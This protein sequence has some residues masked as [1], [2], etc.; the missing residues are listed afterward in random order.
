MKRLQCFADFF[1]KSRWRIFLFSIV[2]TAIEKSPGEDPPAIMFFCSASTLIQSG[3]VLSCL[4]SEKRFY[5][6]KGRGP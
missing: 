2:T 6:L 3:S 5:Y 4:A 1:A